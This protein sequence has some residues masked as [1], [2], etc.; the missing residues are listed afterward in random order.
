MNSVFHEG[1]LAVQRRA[2]VEGMAR[3]V[4]AVIDDTISPAARDFYR[5]QSFVVVG[6]IDAEKRVWASLLTGEPGFIRVIDERT[7]FIESS[8]LRALRPSK[9]FL[10][11]SPSGCSS[12]NPQRGAG[13]V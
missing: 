2:G 6:T 1:E 10:P 8:R 13:C 5:A 3:R 4:S 11:Q 12:S 9:N 7:V